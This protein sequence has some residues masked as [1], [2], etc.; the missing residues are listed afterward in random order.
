MSSLPEIIVIDVI[1]YGI[2]SDQFFDELEVFPQSI[3]IVGSGYI[4]IE[5]A[6]FFSTLGPLSCFLSSLLNHEVPK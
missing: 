6:G 2:S 3:A 4:A 1:E 5:F